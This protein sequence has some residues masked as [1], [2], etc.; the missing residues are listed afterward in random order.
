MYGTAASTDT[1]LVVL[2]PAI[3]AIATTNTACLMLIGV[4]SPP[5]PPVHGK[6]LRPRACVACVGDFLTSPFTIYPP[7]P[8]P[9]PSTTPPFTS[10]VLYSYTSAVKSWKAV[11]LKALS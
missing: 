8:P 5:P 11:A 4:V 10:P 3:T 1:E 7:S 2:T 9:H 6:L